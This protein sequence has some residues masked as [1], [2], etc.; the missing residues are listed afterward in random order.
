M[1]RLEGGCQLPL[2][3]HVTDREVRISL[4][5]VEAKWL[6][7]MVGEGKRGVRR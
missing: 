7:M 6:A 1:R 3:A 5:E 2:G 4:P